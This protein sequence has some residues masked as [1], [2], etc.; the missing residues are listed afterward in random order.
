MLGNQWLWTLSS[1]VQQPPTQFKLDW[2]VVFRIKLS[3]QK[4]EQIWDVLVALPLLIQYVLSLLSLFGAFSGNA[5]LLNL[6]I[7]CA[8]KWDSDLPHTILESF[9]KQMLT[10]QRSAP[11]K[12]W[13][14]TFLSSF[15]LLHPLSVSLPQRLPQESTLSQM[16]GLLSNVWFVFFCCYGLFFLSRFFLFQ[17]ASKHG[18]W[19]GQQS[20]SSGIYLCFTANRDLI[21]LSDY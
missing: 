6:E 3:S 7:Y 12:K 20:F 14:N 10:K 5:K 11:G 13:S 8:N 21:I 9:Q 19:E 17:P 1:L 18:T 15:V 2:N 16:S 4:V